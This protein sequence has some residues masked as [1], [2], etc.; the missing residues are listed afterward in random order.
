MSRFPNLLPTPGSRKVEL[1]STDVQP[2][3]KSCTAAFEKGSQ[4]S[5]LSTNTLLLII[6][7]PGPLMTYSPNIVPLH[8][9]KAFFLEGSGKIA[10][11][12]YSTARPSQL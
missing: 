12:R 5:E 10:L 8:F 7:S 3:Q 9:L 11:H 6:N 1:R 4:G 2:S